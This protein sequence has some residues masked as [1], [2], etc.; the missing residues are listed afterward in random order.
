VW[1]NGIYDLFVL[2]YRNG[3]RVRGCVDDAMIAWHACY[4]ELAGAREDKKKHRFTRKA[5]SFLA[6]LVTYD[7]WWKDYDYKTP[8]EQFTLNG[9]D[10]CTTL[11]VWAWVRDEMQKLGAEATYKHERRLMWPCVDML[12]R[13]LRV[14]EGLRLER[15]GALRGRLLETHA[16]AQEIVV[17][18]VVRERER[19]EEIGALRLFEETEGVCACCRHAVKKQARC[20]GCAGFV[21]SPSKAALIEKF[22]PFNKKRTKEEIEQ[23]MLATCCVCEGRPREVDINVNLNSDAQVKALL[24]DALRVPPRM[25][26]NAKGKSVT[27]VDESALK[28]ILGSL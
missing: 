28:A 26:R 7:P 13:G 17:P 10:V 3:I 25:K 11:D 19:L 23:E 8:E 5:L 9:R 14:N 12:A 16:K 24:Y 6:S 21:K 2:A 18:F 22:G 1:V 20:W 27:T 4:P 15:L